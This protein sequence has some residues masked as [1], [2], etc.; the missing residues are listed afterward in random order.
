MCRIWNQSSKFKITIYYNTSCD[1]FMCGEPL[2]HKVEAHGGKSWR[3]KET[4][5]GK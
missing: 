1:K 3:L 4:S 5:L 2:Y